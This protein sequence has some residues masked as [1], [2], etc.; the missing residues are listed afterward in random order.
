MKIHHINLGAM[1]ALPN[2]PNPKTI[3][4][5]LLLEDDNGLTMID[6]GLGLAEMQYPLELLGQKLMDVWHFEIDPNLSALRQLEAKGIKT[7]DVKRIIMTHL[8]VDHAGGLVDFPHAEVHLSVEEY[9]HWQ[10]PRFVANQFAHQPNW[11]PHGAVEN[12]EQWFG[13]DSRKLALG[14]GVDLRLIPLFGHTFGHCGV[15][16]H[17]GNKWLLHAGDTYYRRI[18]VSSANNPLDPIAAHSADDNTLRLQ[19]LQKVRDLLA[20]HGD[21]VDFFS[22]HDITEFK[23]QGVGLS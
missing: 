14:L 8:D 21:E 12:E 10:S 1:G 23:E 11:K 16:I 4:H 15:A 13:L 3:C 2:D 6:T 5:C 22:T 17:D 9:Q 19:S 7:Q 20:N 18:E